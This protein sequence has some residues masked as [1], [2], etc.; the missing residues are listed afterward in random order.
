MLRKLL[1][2]QNVEVHMHDRLAGIFF[3]VVDN[4]EALIRTGRL[5]DLRDCLQS[6]NYYFIE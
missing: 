5:H 3:A 1:T 6:W 4:T 2:A